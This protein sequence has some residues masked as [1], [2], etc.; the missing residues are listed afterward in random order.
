MDQRIAAACAPCHE[1]PLLI[2][3]FWTD[4]PTWDLQLSRALRGTDWISAIRRL[5]PNA[6][7]R[8]QYAAFLAERYQSR[9]A[10]WNELYGLSLR[11]FADAASADLSAVAIGRHVV[12]EDDEAF[13]ARIAA[14]Y[15]AAAGKSQR[16]HDPNHLVFGE[17]Y[18][19]GD[20][21]ASV[22][23]AAAPYVD[24]FSV[25]PGDQYVRFVPPAPSIPRRSSIA[26]T[27]GP[28]ESL[29]SSAIT[30][31]ASPQRNIPAPSSNR[32]RMTNPPL[33]RPSS[34]CIRPHAPPRILGYLRCQYID[35]PAGFGRGPRQGLLDSHGKPR[36]RLTAAY[37]RGFQDWLNRFSR[38]T[39]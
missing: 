38:E 1:D 26:S 3:W 14:R 23:A 2:G 28:A 11:D 27:T 29:C 32:R 5:P 35:R 24:A 18:L 13:L 25:Q 9:I 20:A 10:A 30:P 36:A 16:R 39:R 8:R 21:P 37:Q 19:A 33:A 12:R 17:R 15:Y 22:I 31:L 7:G 4:T 34:F 6:P